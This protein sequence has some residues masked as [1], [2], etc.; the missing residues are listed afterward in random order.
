MIQALLYVVAFLAIQYLAQFLVVTGYT[1]ITSQ[2]A[3]T[4]PPLC[5]ILIM[6]LFSV[7]A[8]VLFLRQRWATASRSYLQSRPWAEMSSASSQPTPRRLQK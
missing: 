1:L 4:L 2:P 6:V 5:N 3:N 7:A 8:I